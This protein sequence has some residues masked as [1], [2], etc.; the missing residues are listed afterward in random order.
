M[1]HLDTVLPQQLR[2]A[3]TRQLEDLRRVDGPRG[4]HDFAARAGLRDGAADLVFDAGAALAVEQ[5]AQ[6]VRL[7]HHPQ[8]R[9]AHRRAQVAERGAHAPPAADRRLCLD[10]ALLVFAVVVRVSLVAGGNGGGEQRVIQRVLVRDFRNMQRPVGAAD[11][12][13]AVLIGF[14]ALEHRTNILPAPAAA[15]H[16]RPGVVIERLTAHEHQPV[17]RTGTAEH[18]SPRHRDLPVRRAGLG[19][20]EEA[21]V[22][23]GVVDEQAET[24]GQPRERMRRAARLQQQHPHRRILRQPRGQRRAGRSR[25]DDDVVVAGVAAVCILRSSRWCRLSCAARKHTRKRT[26][27]KR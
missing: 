11:A 2:T 13:R 9:P 25:A 14:H 22:H 16:L 23:R 17:D 8:V 21:P 10:H 24:D 3:D 20:G 7:R 6:R 27:V 12:A 1:P 26:E 4:Q 19:L 5:H 15:A 18:F